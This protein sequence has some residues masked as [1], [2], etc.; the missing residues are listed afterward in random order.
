MAS[1]STVTPPQQAQVFINF[2]GEE[3]RNSFVSHLLTALERKGLKFY[4]D[5]REIRSE[6]LD[7]LFERID[8]SKIALAIFSE[9]Y[10]ESNWCLNELGRIMRN[11][12]QNKIRIIPIFF[13]VTPTDVKIQVGKFGFN[14][15][16]GGRYDLPQMTQWRKDL[17]SV[18][19]NLGMC[20]STYGNESR[21]L[22]EICNEVQKVIEKISSDSQSGRG[23]NML[24]TNT[25]TVTSS[26]SNGFA[27]GQKLEAI[28]WKEGKQWDDGAANY[29]VAKIYIQGGPEGIQYIK[30]DYVN[31]GKSID[32]IIHGTLADGFTHTVEMDYH[33]YE[34]IEYVEG[35]Y[36]E[37]TNVVQALQFTTNLKKSEFIG[38][39]KG[40]KFSLGVN[41]KFIS[42]FHGSAEQYLHS[43]G[44]YLS[45]PSTKSELQGGRGGGK[46]DDG[47]NSGVRKVYV[48]FTKDY[49]KSMSIE[50]DQVGK[51]V[52][53]FHGKKNGKTQE[54][55]VDFPNEYITS[56]EGTFN[57]TP[58]FVALTSLT[59]KTSKN[60]TSQTF[61]SVIGTEFVLWKHG[62]V[63]VGF[64]GSDGDAFD[65]IGAYFA[66]MPPTKSELQGGPGGG[67]KWDDGPNYGVRKVYVTFTKDYIKSMDI[68]Y[69]RVGKVVKRC[70]GKKNGET[71]EFAVDFPNEYI[72]SVEGTF[73]K[74]RNFVA[75][76]SLTFK[77]SKKSTSQTFGSAI[78]TEFVLWKH[79]NVIVGFHG[80][81][82]VAFDNIGVYFAPMPPTKSELQ[83][84]PGG[85]NK[86]DDGPNYGVRKVYVTFTKDYI[87]SMDIDYDQ[88][89]KVV[90]RCHGEKNG[91]TQEF[92]VDFPNEYITSVEGTFNKIRNF[93]ALTSLTFKT[94][95]KSTSQT[96]GS[97][98]GI[99]FVL[100]R[101]GN[102]IVGFHGSDGVAFDNI[103]VYFAPMPP[104][105][106]ELQGL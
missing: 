1:A 93:V 12:K 101:N 17:N 33:K 90:K 66:P 94:S 25:S 50:Y 37:N 67:N 92:A 36:N 104:T 34:Q 106:S 14:L 100:W 22:D 71:Q 16:Q 75:L 49:I 91:E 10:G 31:S 76:T 63:I 73:N 97:V 9:K 82:G 40:T 46:W 7:I 19:G 18:V 48:T 65:N 98:T 96:F 84:G 26:D 11:V 15:L 68:D 64:H 3:V 95:K 74:T 24:S 28:G 85:G 35:Y 57:K 81:D 2:R 23:D 86:W 44:V 41:G 103:G 51:V 30:F 62:N 20:S 72:T 99:E 80:S 79:D 105:K 29:C 61:G 70:H 6:S 59:F 39:R 45:N 102:V 32:G 43:L 77:T 56:V 83:G 52:T 88:V 78:G 89:G 60:S 38:Y 27:M 69:D 87:K 58:G 47:P 55:A 53:R 8:E 42:S 4:I 13:N 21:F 5:Q 54:F